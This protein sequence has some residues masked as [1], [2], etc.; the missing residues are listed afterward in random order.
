MLL[1]IGKQMFT[2]INVGKGT[3]STD[4]K[5]IEVAIAASIVA[6][7]GI[8]VYSEYKKISKEPAIK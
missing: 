5:I 8:K 1:E 3:I 4:N 7:I 6:L 2:D